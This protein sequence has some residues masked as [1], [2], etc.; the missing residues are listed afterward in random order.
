MSLDALVVGVACPRPRPPPSYAPP[1]FFPSPWPVLCLF[2]GG[3]VCRRVR[4]VSSSRL[5]AAAW[6]WWTASSD[7]ASSAWAEW[8]FG[9]LLVGPLNVAQGVTR[10]GGGCQPRRWGCT[11]LQLRGCPSPFRLF[12]LGGPFLFVGYGGPFGRLLFVGGWGFPPFLS[13]WVFFWGWVRLTVSVPCRDAVVC[14]DV[15]CCA[16]RCFAV[17]LRAVP[18]CAVLRSAPLRRVVP[19]CVV[20]CLAVLWRAA[21]CRAASRRVVLCCAPLRGGVVC[22]AAVWRAVMC[23]V[24]LCCGLLCRAVRWVSCALRAAWDCAGAGRTGGSAVWVAGSGHVL[25][26]RLVGV[27]WLGGA[28]WVGAAGV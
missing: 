20:L 11:A 19:C 16:V 24:V 4:G 26:W 28:R 17:S 27:V 3:G 14:F 18:R 5:S 25:S 6:S 7:S 10:P 13:C 15:P 8:S 22:C 23:S 12:P 21:V 2:P 9:V 1:L